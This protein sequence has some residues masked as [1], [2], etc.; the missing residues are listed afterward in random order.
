M[1]EPSKSHLAA[2]VKRRHGL[3]PASS[4]EVHVLVERPGQRPEE[5]VVRVFDLPGSACAYR[6]FAW[7]ERAPDGGERIIT[8]IHGPDWRS[9]E[10]AVRAPGS[11][12]RRR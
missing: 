7:V 5:R 4:E 6:A 12:D 9:N 8:K 1:S 2:L 10:A 11:P 3:E